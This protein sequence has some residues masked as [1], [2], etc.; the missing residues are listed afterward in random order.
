MSDSEP[1]TANCGETIL[2]FSPSN[3][4]DTG[5]HTCWESNRERHQ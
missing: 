2:A 3:L 5:V 1:D 4:T